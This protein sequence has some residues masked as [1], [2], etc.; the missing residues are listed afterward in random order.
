MKR[1]EF[2]PPKGWMP[3]EGMSS[4]DTFDQLCSFRMKA[5]GD[6]CLIAIGETPMP[7]YGDK[8]APPSDGMKEMGDRYSSKVRETMNGGEY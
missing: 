8:P 5:N 4:G 1:V 6:I 3:P 7:G 2:K